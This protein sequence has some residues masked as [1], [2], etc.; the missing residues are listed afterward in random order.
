MK[1]FTLLIPWIIATLATLGSL[2]YGEVRNEPPCTLCWY[3]RILMFPLAIILGIATFRKAHRIVLYALP[4]A[5]LGFLALLHLIGG[6]IISV[7]PLEALP[8]EPEQ[9]LEH[10]FS[11]LV[12]GLGQ[13]PLIWYASKWLFLAKDQKQ[14]S[15][16]SSHDLN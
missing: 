8:F 12:Y 6:A 5:A 2:F 4:M 16:A 14:T 13:L 10:Y 3:Q 11:H 9:S 1:R 7:L 15:A